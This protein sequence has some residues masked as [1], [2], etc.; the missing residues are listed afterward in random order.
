M[1]AQELHLDDPARH[2][3]YSGKLTRRAA[4]D[5]V[6]VV[7]LDHRLL[8]ARPRRGKD[9]EDQFEIM[10]DVRWHTHIY[11]Q[12]AALGTETDLTHSC[13]RGWGHSSCIMTR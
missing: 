9:G 4:G 6:L 13:V 1:P 8:L 7:L 3:L 2:I 5:E 10:R 11:T 12:A